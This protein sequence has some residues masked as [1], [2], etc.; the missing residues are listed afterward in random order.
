MHSWC[1]KWLNLRT[2]TRSFRDI[3]VCCRQSALPV[4]RNLS[5]WTLSQQIHLLTWHASYS[6]RSHQSG[7][8]P[9]SIHCIFHSF[10]SVVIEISGMGRI[11]YKGR[12][13]SPALPMKWTVKAV[14]QIWRCECEKFCSTFGL[15]R[16]KISVFFCLIL[17]LQV[18]LLTLSPLKDR[19]LP[20]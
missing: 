6:Q 15:S 17:T 8:C 20:M 10:R 7:L 11:F 2:L 18:Y 16:F 1:F 3:R 5:L 14:H 13:Q 19:E 4:S 12:Q 9:V